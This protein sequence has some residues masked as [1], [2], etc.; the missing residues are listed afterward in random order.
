MQDKGKQWIKL[1]IVCRHLKDSNDT[2]ILARLSFPLGL[3]IFT[4]IN[5]L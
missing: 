5:G 1:G 2:D 3:C 4:Y